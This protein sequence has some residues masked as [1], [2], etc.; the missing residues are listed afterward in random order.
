MTVPVEEILR[1]TKLKYQ[2]SKIAAILKDYKEILRMQGVL[3]DGKTRGFADKQVQV[4]LDTVKR[5]LQQVKSEAENML[6]TFGQNGGFEW[7]KWFAQKLRDVTT[8]LRL[9]SQEAAEGKTNM[10]SLAKGV[11]KVVG[12][13]LILR[14]LSKAIGAGVKAYSAGKTA[15]NKSAGY[16]TQGVSAVAGNMYADSRRAGQERGTIVA[17]TLTGRSSG[18]KDTAETQADTAAHKANAAATREST[19]AHRDDANANAR[20]A[21]A[22]NENTASTTANT[23]AHTGNAAGT[24]ASAAGKHVDT[25]ANER[26]TAAETRNTVSTNT[27]TRSKTRNASVTRV[28]ARAKATDTI[29]T[30]RDTAS[31]AGNTAENIA[32]AGATNQKSIATMASSA[33]NTVAAGTTAILTGAVRGLNAALAA[34]GG[35][36]GIAVT[37]L[38]TF[39]TS[40]LFS[41]DSAGEAANATQDAMDSLDESMNKIS[42][43]FD[44]IERQSDAAVSVAEAYNKVSDSLATCAE[45]S[46]EYAK[47]KQQLADMDDTLTAILGDNAQKFRTENGYNIQSIREHE[48]AV[49]KDKVNEQKQV[50]DTAT[51]SAD[52]TKTQIESIKHTIS[53]LKEEVSS[54]QSTGNAWLWLKS[55]IAR[56]RLQAAL[57]QK[58]Y[59]TDLLSYAENS[60][61]GGITGWYVNTFFGGADALRQ[62]ASDQ[63]NKADEK[64]KEAEE[65]MSG[66]PYNVGD[67]Q[68][69]IA[70]L[71]EEEANLEE[72][73]GEQRK[74]AANAGAL[75]AEMSKK[76][77]D[78]A[79]PSPGKEVDNNNY[80]K[81]PR[82]RH[83]RTPH[84][85]KG[86]KKNFDYDPATTGAFLAVAQQY[87]N[88]PAQHLDF[89]HIAEIAARVTGR[90]NGDFSGIT[91]PFRNGSSNFWDSAYNFAEIMERHFQKGESLTDALSAEYP[92]IFGTTD[93]Q[94]Q[95]S[96]AKLD[97]DARWLTDNF[98]LKRNARRMSDPNE[99]VATASVSNTGSIEALVA[100]TASKYRVDPKL[101]LQVAQHES[102]FKADEI[103][104][105]GAIGVMQLMPG[106]AEKLGVNPYDTNQNIDGGIRYLKQMLDKFSDVGTAL[107]A[108]NAGPGNV[109][110]G[111]G[112]AQAVLAEDVSAAQAKVSNAN[113]NVDPLG[114]YRVPKEYDFHGFDSR[115][116]DFDGYL[117]PEA[118][119]KLDEVPSWVKT[120][121]SKI[122]NDYSYLTNGGKIHVNDFNAGQGHAAGPNGH[123][124]GLKVDTNIDDNE[125]ALRQILPIYGVSAAMES[126][127]HYDWSF[128]NGGDGRAYGYG[129]TSYNTGA[130][131]YRRFSGGFSQKA[132]KAQ[133]PQRSRWNW[134]G[135]SALQDFYI[136]PVAKHEYSDKL[137]KQQYDNAKKNNELE[138]KLYGETFKLEQ[139]GRNLDRAFALSRDVSQKY[140]ESLYDIAKKELKDYVDTHEGAKAALG[141]ETIDTIDP[142]NLKKWA[143]A[144]NDPKIKDIASFFTAAKE[145]Y[146]ASFR[147]SHETHLSTLKKR[148]VLTPEES[149]QYELDRMKRK[150]ELEDAGALYVHPSIERERILDELAVYEKMEARQERYKKDADKDAFDEIKSIRGIMGKYRGNINRLKEQEKAGKDVTK[151]IKEQN[152][153]YNEQKVLLDSIIRYGTPGQRKAQKNL[154]ETRKRIKELNKDLRKTESEL[155]E[156]VKDGF[157]QMFENVLLEGG[158]FRDSFKALW[159]DIAR[160]AL[161]QIMKIHV[162]SRL[163]GLFTHSPISPGGG[164]ARAADTA[165]DPRLAGG[166]V[167]PG[168]ADGGQPGGAITGAG[169]GKSDDILAYVADKDRF[170][171][172]SNGEYVMTAEATKRIGKGTLDR[173]NYGKYAD[174]GAIEPTPYIPNLSTKVTKTAASID[175]TNPNAKL[176][177]LMGEQNN[178]LRSIGDNENGGNMVVLNT[179]ASSDDV[180]S[181]LAKNPRMVQRILGNQ[182]R[183]GFR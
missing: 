110:A 144:L 86:P 78:E 159:K 63:W 180:M 87:D 168:F 82:T 149:E 29:Q 60:D 112:Y 77:D 91:D 154:D 66:N 126:G 30:R 4:Q 148:G 14:G 85:R 175:R 105:M 72:L 171:Y 39:G 139:F 56:A 152:D 20:D 151:E 35:P 18:T 67:L 99:K 172:L 71:Q 145:K 129:L 9:M 49:L 138:Q 123:Y 88:F 147:E 173:M 3:N 40:L 46:D 114:G 8:G 48:Q 79:N 113:A 177:S 58:K 68:G 178:L 16:Q 166:G 103:S 53:A 73:E 125:W 41:A 64:E 61:G 136:N 111:R 162:Y 7:L 131:A 31:T 174:G 2:Y 146:D 10:L 124:A 1:A 90:T 47:K 62:L 44:Q 156:I 135:M 97:N 84:E 51:T 21:A 50:A 161:E 140:W 34:L 55:V 52:A 169:T 70:E 69:R 165:I 26:D 158:S 74:T 101:A 142:T 76:L 94:K 93:A 157:G 19:I 59:A 182:Q 115:Y 164:L 54:I 81:E 43:D 132:Q 104:P 89:A 183:H 83:P 95:A 127:T 15:W 120:L 102:H 100:S 108:Y 134:H 33:A 109:D 38:T 6:A 22:E 57:E 12:V 155:F 98:D 122:G 176:E 11:T 106:T 17:A 96:Q 119:D 121:F 75:A 25:S 92:D 179:H 118:Y 13:L 5:K 45:T 80:G 153:L 130:E 133:L 23:S 116:I 181:A 150:S 128:G 32:N 65:E 107:A 137:D 24:N 27:N 117:H 28:S 141:K 167:I 170:V 160:F 42:Q 163:A 37:L 143:E 36:V